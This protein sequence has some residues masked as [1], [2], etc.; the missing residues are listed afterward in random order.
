VGEQEGVVSML[1]AQIWIAALLSLAAASCEVVALF[2]S[3]GAPVGAVVHGRIT[4]CGTAVIGAQVRLLVQQNRPEQNRPVDSR[5]G[6]VVT[7]RDGQYI[8]DVGPSFA[9]PGPASMEMEVTSRGVT[10]SIPGGTL[11]LRMG[12][13]PN[14]TTRFDADLG[15]EHGS[16]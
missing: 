5:I 11:E 3:T 10:D 7:T 4:F 15:A 12:L 6:P 14:D 9:V 2:I 8:M 1:G 13:P 16:C